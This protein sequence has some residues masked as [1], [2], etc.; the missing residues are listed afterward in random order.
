MEKDP[1]QAVKWMRLAATKLPEAQYMMGMFYLDGLGVVQ[2]LAEAAKWL[3]KA[4]D[5]NNPDA[6]ALLSGMY[7]FGRGMPQDFQAA[8]VLAKE[9][10]EQG[11]S[12]GQFF[13]AQFSSAEREHL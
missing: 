3:R 8:Y 13:F 7:F 6:K 10:A 12:T 4:V 5:Q 2:D 9:A 1:V 11:N